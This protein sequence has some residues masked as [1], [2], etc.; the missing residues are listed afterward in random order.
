MKKESR[1]F[2]GTYIEESAYDALVEMAKKEQRSVASMLKVFVSEGVQHLSL[3]RRV[4]N[5]K[6]AA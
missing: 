4:C 6:R 5:T 1:K 3:R 2:V